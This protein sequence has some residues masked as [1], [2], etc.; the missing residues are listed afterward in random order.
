MLPGIVKLDNGPPTRDDRRLAALIYAGDGSVITGLD[1]LQLHGMRRMPH[2]S[3][4]VHVLIPT[5]RRRVGAGR[6]LAERTERLPEPAA[7]RW[8]LAPIARAALDFARRSSD[9]DEVRATIAEV[10]QQGR[11]SAADLCAELEAGS[12]RG[13]ALPRDV[14]REIA[15]GV[16]SVAEADARRLVARSGLPQP[17]YNPR[18]LD[19][20][21]R[22]VAVPD[23]WF[24]EVALA[25]EI[26]SREFHLSPEEY[27]RTLDR[28]SAMMAEGV[29]VMH[30]QPRKLRHRR[31]EI[32]D[33]LR[34]N[35]AQAALRPRPD[36]VAVPE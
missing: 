10:V 9:R 4:P 7:G 17:L 13:S 14:L 32:V 3:G 19:K 30:S 23:V 12:S 8:S 29:I 28:R 35:Y 16:R 21:G 15:D 31:T 20:H 36:V 11:C 26:D 6:V 34:R 1:A 33:E 18:L 24:D 2:P 27:D 5:G 25:W 22:F